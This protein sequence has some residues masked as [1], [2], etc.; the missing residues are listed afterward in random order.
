M[1]RPMTSV[2]LVCTASLWPALA[3]AN[4]PVVP[5]AEW[6]F[7]GIRSAL[8]DGYPEVR[9]IAATK[10]AQL[11]WRITSEQKRRDY[12]ILDDLGPAAILELR[13]L[14]D[15]DWK[16]AWARALIGGEEE[17]GKLRDTPEVEAYTDSGSYAMEVGTGRDVAAPKDAKTSKTAGTR[18]AVGARIAAMLALGRL[19]DRD[20]AN[21]LVTYLGQD[22]TDGRGPAARALGELRILKKLEIVPPGTVPALRKLLKDPDVSVQLDAATALARLGDQKDRDEGIAVLR[23]HMGRRNND[24]SYEKSAEALGR[25]NTVEAIPDLQA[26]LKEVDHTISGP[27]ARALALMGRREAVP[28]ICVQVKR[29]GFVA[30]EFTSALAILGAEKEL[31]EFA[32]DSSVSEYAVKALGEMGDRKA[33]S[34]LRRLLTAKS[35]RSVLSEGKDTALAVALGRLGDDTEFPYLLDKIRKNAY[36]DSAAVESL[37][38]LGPG[39]A[40]HYLQI[41]DE[42]T[43]ATVTARWLAH[44]SGAEENGSDSATG[45]LCRYLARPATDPEPVTTREEARRALDVLRTAWDGSPSRWVKRDVAAAWAQIILDPKIA[46]TSRDADE[47]LKPVR[48]RLSAADNP[49][50]RGYLPGIDKVL[51]PFDVV[52]PV[53]VRTLLAFGA[54]NLIATLL[55]VFRPGRR[56]VENWLP[57]IGLTGAGLGSWVANALAE[58]FLDPW[59]LG[60]LLAGE[61]LVLSCAGFLSPGVLRHVS[62][63]EPLNRLVVPLALRLPWSRRR[64]FREYV[65][66]LRS[67][68]ARDMDRASAE[69]Y[70]ALPAVVKTSAD[71]AAASARVEPAA[72]VLQFLMDEAVGRCHV[73][74]EA[75]GGRGKSAVL[76]EVVREAL[77]RFEEFPA[78]TPLPVLLAGTG[79]SVEAMTREALGNFPLGREFVERLLEAGDFFLVLDGV[80]ESGLAAPALL[81]FV[82]GRFGGTTSLLVSARPTR[83]FRDVVEG[84]AR[85]MSVEPSRMDESLLAAF[86]AHYGGGE[87]A[88]PVKGACRGPDGYLPILVR[89]AMTVGQAQARPGGV[90]VAD[91]Y[92]SYFLKLFEAQ[93]PDEQVR[94]AQLDEAAR[95]GLETYWRDGRRRR[96]YEATDL[97]RR[98]MGAGI[99]VPA[100]ALQP[101][102]EVQFFHDSMQ[103]YLTAYG[104]W[105]QDREGYIKLPTPRGDGSGRPWDRARVLLRAASDTVFSG[106]AAE[107]HGP[108]GTELFQMCTA[109]FAPVDELC[110]W[111]RNELRVWAETH[112]DDLRRRD[113][114][115]A[116]PTE[117]QPEVASARG[118]KGLLTRAID[119]CFAADKY[120]QSAERVSRLYAGI[121]V[122]VHDLEVEA[123][124]RNAS[125]SARQSTDGEPL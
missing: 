49:I 89:M 101:P 60:G 112:G 40:I 58:L 106:S 68:L 23:T 34:E 50:G 21:T 52:P 71:R 18:K 115:G 102:K 8:K 31:L 12:P 27:A 11:C 108:A 124:V 70:L 65:A 120:R 42:A 3:R 17:R 32:R 57:L 53:W 9:K 35:E 123:G 55:F 75:P 63:L 86:V 48:D 43:A 125:E 77:D 74:I 121:A 36:I 41:P 104:L 119:A 94:F 73:L 80:S 37:E 38:S 44:Y 76:R 13:K 88:A 39:R 33:A 22:G 2:V 113:V 107:V 26:L 47:V 103:S 92:R 118:V 109:V 69:R 67:R 95:W 19:G 54:I 51:R 87:L 114:L 105:V 72:D 29:G 59:L 66:T 20:A 117:L 79:E 6:Q 24:N 56:G 14:E 116:V 5:V 85:W 1:H 90:T 30:R 122:L 99:L 82:Q 62:Q 64:L 93:Y 25:L 81:Q 7:K 98:L 15:P 45:I 10:L 110:D 4:E 96:A 100:D 78:T 83:A 28:E 97:Q 84:T 91:L 46:W 111:L 61:L 16:V